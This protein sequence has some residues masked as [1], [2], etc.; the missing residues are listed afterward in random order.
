MVSLDSIDYPRVRVVRI[1]EYTR[2]FEYSSILMLINIDIFRNK[3][4]RFLE[5]R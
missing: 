1:L 4:E 2:V 5:A 3:Q